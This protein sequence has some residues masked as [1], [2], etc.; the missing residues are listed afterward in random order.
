MDRI[1]AVFVPLVIS[2]A[3]F[4]FLAWQIFGGEGAI[5]HGLAA[6][7]SVLVIACPCALGLATP[8]AVMVGVGKGAQSGIL[9]RDAEAM[10]LARLV[11]TVVL[12]KTGT[13]T[14]GKPAVT[15]QVW[16]DE[17]TEREHEHLRQALLAVELR[18]EHPLAKAIV[19]QLETEQVRPLPDQAVTR[20]ES[21]TAAGVKLQL[22]GSEWLLV[23]NMRLLKAEATM[24]PEALAKAAERLEA[25]AK[26]VIFVGFKGRAVAVLAIADPLKE[27]SVTA[28]A[29]LKQS[30]IQ[31]HMLTGDNE[32]TAAA[33]A[34]QVGIDSFKAQVLPAD[35]SEFIRMLRD[36]GKTVAMVGDGVNDSEALA[37]ANVSI[38]MGHGSDV[39]MQVASL[40]LMT[41]NLE[42]VSKAIRLSNLTVATI[43]RN[44]F[45][46]FIYNIV[47]IPVAAGVLF[48]VNG[49]LLDPML[50]GGAMAL[51][52]VSVVLSSLYLRTQKL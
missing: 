35:K 5:S 51:S 48:P 46:A 41:G 40:T 25:E 45:W 19:A 1:S 30:G 23:G 29:M 20:F 22:H 15:D 50:A 44:L 33:V 6:A 49:Y 18:S 17:L 31:V 8:T 9:V 13:L 32:K 42:A 7:I 28:I 12:D 39:A 4:T 2:L 26:T 38:A 10:E 3:G 37:L 21:V 34:G 52:S 43:K 11:N 47:A 14:Q 16:L 36:Q 27:T 24:L